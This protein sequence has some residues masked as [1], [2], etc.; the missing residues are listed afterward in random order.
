MKASRRHAEVKGRWAERV[1]AWSC[2]LRGFRVLAERYRTPV[3]E[4]DLVMR[5]GQLLVF[6]EVKARAV[7][8]EA[9]YALRPPQRERLARAAELFLRDHPIH[10]ACMMRFDLI[11]I[12]PWR[13][14]LHIRDAWRPD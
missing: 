7:F 1:A 13:L 10:G 5:R 11:A 8:E 9:L 6:V 2:R 12:S 14:P 3:G 4:I